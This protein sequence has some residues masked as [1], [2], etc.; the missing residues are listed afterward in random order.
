MDTLEIADEYYFYEGGETC[1]D[2]IWYYHACEYC[3]EKAPNSV[4]ESNV[5]GAHA[6]GDLIPATEAIHTATEL[7]GAVGAHYFCDVCKTYFD[8]NYVETTL[9]M[10]TGAAPEHVDSDENG[11]CDVCEPTIPDDGGD[12]SGDS[13]EPDSSEPDSS[14]PDSSSKD[15]GKKSGCGSTI[16]GTSLGM[17]TLACAGAFVFLKKRKEN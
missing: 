17:L 11:K 4:W 15:E 5:Y 9:E 3:Y 8:E 13:S 10:L 2:K 1:A 6:Y 16:T 7:K 12:N 14:T